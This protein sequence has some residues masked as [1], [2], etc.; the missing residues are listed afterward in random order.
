MSSSMARTART[1]RGVRLARARPVLR[2]HRRARLADKASTPDER[3]GAES[4]FR[5]RENGF[6]YAIAQYGVPSL[7]RYRT[8]PE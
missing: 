7:C 4:L 1:D 8:F 5:A 3:D 6:G 2:G